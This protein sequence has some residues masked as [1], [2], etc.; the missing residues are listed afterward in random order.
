MNNN[1]KRIVKNT[2]IQ[3]IKIIISVIGAF[4]ATRIV[5]QEIGVDDY[6]IFSVIAGLI[7]LLEF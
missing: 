3:Y 4:F 7:A 6:G 2:I 5:L 1:N